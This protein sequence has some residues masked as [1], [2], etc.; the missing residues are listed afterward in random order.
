[1]TLF[2]STVASEAHGP[3]SLPGAGG[4]V[5]KNWEGATT[6]RFIILDNSGYKSGSKLREHQVT[7]SS[8][9][10]RTRS[11]PGVSR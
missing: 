6:G 4:G 1:M 5:K 2:R 8:G 10:S 7:T 3:E 11:S 9:L